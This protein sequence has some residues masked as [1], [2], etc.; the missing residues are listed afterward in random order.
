MKRLISRL[1]FS[2]FLLASFCMQAQNTPEP[3]KVQQAVIQLFDGIAALD[4]TM[5]KRHVT[6]DFVLLEDGAVWTTDTLINKLNPLKAARF[7]RINHLRF[8]QTDVKGNTAWVAYYNTADMTINE[9]KRTANWLESAFLVKQG[10]IW[11]IRLLH[12]TV[13]NPN[14]K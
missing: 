4:E 8:I 10:G 12:S 3:A 2:F 11:K 9:T 1:P 13:V 6:T 7:S 5:I 14:K